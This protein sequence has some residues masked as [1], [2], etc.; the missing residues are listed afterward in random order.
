MPEDVRVTC[1]Q[2]GNWQ[3]H[4]RRKVALPIRRLKLTEWVLESQQIKAVPTGLQAVEMIA[5]CSAC[6][7]TVE[8]IR[9]ESS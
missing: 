9:M 6:H 7:F 3:I 8:Y 1:D 4:H 2:C 5:E